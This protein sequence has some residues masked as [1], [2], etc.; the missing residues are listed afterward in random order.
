MLPS[1]PTLLAAAR[2]SWPPDPPEA[3]LPKLRRLEHWEP[4][5]GTLRDRYASLGE[6]A[7]AAARGIESAF[8]GR[9]AAMV[10]HVV[11]TSGLRTTSPFVESA[12]TAFESS[13]SAA[14]LA[15]LA[16]RG[17]PETYGVKRAKLETVRAV[18]ERLHQYAEEAGL[19]EEAA[20]RRWASEALAFELQPT[21]EPWVGRVPGVDATTLATMGRCC[22][23]DAVRPD[24]RLW[25]GLRRL[26]FPLPGG[27]L[28][29]EARMDTIVVVTAAAAQLSLPRAVVDET[30]VR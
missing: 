23:A 12:R 28:T 3:L 2:D 5:V 26:G 25:E 14:S 11:V 4:A 6:E 10:F 15:V 30:A 8:V 19:D 20:V 24:R 27:W 9:R 1:A 29:D 18:A 21:A 17:V 16:D 22:G 13:Q 7:R